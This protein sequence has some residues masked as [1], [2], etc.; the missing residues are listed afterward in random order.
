MPESYHCS[1]CGASIALADVNVANDIALC[2]QCGKTMAFS[3]IAP[4]PGAAEVDLERPP[5]GVRIEDSPLGGRSMIYRKISPVVLFLIPF[6]AVW[7]GGSMS[8]I[9]GSQIQKGHFELTQSLFGVPF[10]LGSVVLVSVILFLLCGRWRI[11]HTPGLLEVAIEIGPLGWT[12]RLACDRSA[13]VSL[14]TSTWQRNGAPQQVIQVDCQANTLKFGTGIPDQAKAFIAE[15]LRR[16][17][18]EG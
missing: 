1:S 4:L 9:Y 10:L 18:A 12:R 16:T 17:L 3:L 7:S 6:T 13:R 2:R 5:K 14:Q 15:V 11:R 8:A